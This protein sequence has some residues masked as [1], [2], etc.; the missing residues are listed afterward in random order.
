MKSDDS[1]IC[2]NNYFTLIQNRNNCMKV[3]ILF[4]IQNVKMQLDVGSEPT[5]WYARVTC[6]ILDRDL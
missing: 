6:I 2:I 3:S 4:K 5:L 1:Y